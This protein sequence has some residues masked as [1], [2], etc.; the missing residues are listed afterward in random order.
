MYGEE[1]EFEPLV[2]IG[3]KDF[4]RDGVAGGEICVT[5]GALDGI[6]RIL[7]EHL[8][9]GDRV[10]V[11]D[12]GFGSIF[13]LVMSLGLSLVPIRVDKQGIVPAQ[14]DAACRAGAKAV[15]VLA[16]RSESNRGVLYGGARRGVAGR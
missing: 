12:P 6:E 3:R 8:R 16:A 4:D 15:I 10:G 13:D 1:N 9:A 7:I 14:L 11:E 2:K 5:N